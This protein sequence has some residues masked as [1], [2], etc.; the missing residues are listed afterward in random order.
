MGEKFCR[1]YDILSEATGVSRFELKAIHRATK[2]KDNCPFLG[3]SG[4]YPSAIRRFKEENQGFK[5]SL[6]WARKPR[7]AKPDGM[8]LDQ[9][10]EVSGKLRGRR[11]R[12][13][14]HTPSLAIPEHLVEQA[15]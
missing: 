9:P 11:V 6:Q 7:T 10:V 8:I 1:N 2:G 15:S 13:D 12:N 5:P 4:A 14:P 3:R